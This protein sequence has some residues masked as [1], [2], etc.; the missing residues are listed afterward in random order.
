MEPPLVRG[1]RRLS[2]PFYFVLHCSAM[3][4]PILIFAALI[5]VAMSGCDSDRIGRLE[6]QNQELQAQIQ[7]QQATANL[8]SQSK[9]AHDARSWFNENWRRD[10]DT[11]LLDYTNHYNK[12]KN[13]CFIVVE[14]HYGLSDGLSWGNDMTLW[15]VYE[16]AKFGHFYESHMVYPKNNFKPVDEVITCDGPDKKCTGIDEFN[17]FLSPYMNN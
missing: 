7:K 8:D 3:V 12:E 4:R 14:Y 9:C 17:N 6:K 5:F 11:R 1:A 16:N 10:K 2:A 15:D 13:K